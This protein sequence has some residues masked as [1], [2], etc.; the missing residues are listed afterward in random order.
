MAQQKDLALEAE[1]A[2]LRE[3]LIQTNAELNAKDEHTA[4]RMGK[5]EAKNIELQQ[6]C[7][8]LTARM[9]STEG[10]FSELFSK[11]AA[12]YG[13]GRADRRRKGAAA[14]GLKLAGNRAVS[15]ATGGE[16]PAEEGGRA[17]FAG[18]QP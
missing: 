14:A 15:S 4:E 11:S 16:G 2:R 18:D 7:E 9:A 1:N 8:Q 10:V 5:A 13:Y 12:A 3:L 6:R 17:G